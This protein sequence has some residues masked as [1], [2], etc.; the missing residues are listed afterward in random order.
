V[1]LLH[2]PVA[3]VKRQK[4]LNTEIKKVRR[5]LSMDK[6]SQKSQKGKFC[7]PKRA[8][9]QHQNFDFLFYLGWSGCFTQSKHII[10]KVVQS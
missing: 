4:L 2:H 6:A 10:M 3:K 7:I 9:L 1:V 5:K 8:L